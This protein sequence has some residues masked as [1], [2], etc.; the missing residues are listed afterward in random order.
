MEMKIDYPSGKPVTVTFAAPE[1]KADEAKQPGGKKE[2]RVIKPKHWPTAVL[3]VQPWGIVGTTAIFCLS[4]L[5][6][7]FGSLWRALF[8]SGD[9]ANGGEQKKKVQ[10]K[11]K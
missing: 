4:V 2:P 6:L 1:P 9:S 5:Y 10:D 7:L 3:R 8:S 11:A